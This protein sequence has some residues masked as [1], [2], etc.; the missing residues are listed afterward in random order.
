MKKTKSIAA[1]IF[2][3][4]FVILVC[5]TLSGCASLSGTIGVLFPDGSRMDIGSDG[6]QVRTTIRLPVGYSK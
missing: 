1:T 6:K 2:L 3:L 5:G 4:A